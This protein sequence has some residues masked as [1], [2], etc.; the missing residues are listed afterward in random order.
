MYLGRIVER[1][2]TQEVFDDPRH[3]YTRALLSAIPQLDPET[4]VEKIRL[5]GDVPSPVRP[6]SG[7]HFHPRCRDAMEK[8]PAAFP[9]RFF[10]TKTHSCRCWLYEDEERRA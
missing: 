6:P 7:C 9:E 2:R 5:A 4:G 8:C 10:F 1:G 3:P